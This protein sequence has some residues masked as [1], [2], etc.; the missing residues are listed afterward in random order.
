MG[1]SG[2]RLAVIKEYGTFVCLYVL[3]FLNLLLLLL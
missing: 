3:M 2:G 1:E